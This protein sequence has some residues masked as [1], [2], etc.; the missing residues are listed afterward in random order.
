MWVANRGK[1]NALKAYEAVLER[2]ATAGVKIDIVLAMIRMNMFFDD[3]LAV[4][5]GIDRA[6]T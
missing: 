4:A 2:T 3:K 6:K 5:K 1:E